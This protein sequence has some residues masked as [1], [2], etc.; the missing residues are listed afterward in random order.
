MENKRIRSDGGMISSLEWSGKVSK[1]V[2]SK[3]SKMRWL[4]GEVGFSWNW[5]PGGLGLGRLER[6]DQ[7]SH[8]GT[9]P[10]LPVTWSLI[11][12]W[13]GKKQGRES[14]STSL[15]VG[16]ETAVA[17]AFFQC[18][19]KWCVLWNQQTLLC[20]HRCTE[21]RVYPDR[22]GLRG[23]WLLSLGTYNLFPLREFSWHPQLCRSRNLSPEEV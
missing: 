4:L 23:K 7:R 14:N 10:H 22:K 6:Q 18:G 3:M 8:K 11:W 2:V 21:G 13:L 1:M 5:G 9:P 12:K 16:K 15:D 20:S 17:M 19:E